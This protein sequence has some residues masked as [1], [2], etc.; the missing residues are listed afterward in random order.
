MPIDPLPLG[1]QTLVQRLADRLAQDIAAGLWTLLLPGYRTLA[2][3]YGTSRKTCSAALDLLQSRGVLDSATQGARRRIIQ[4]GT[5]PRPQDSKKKPEAGGVLLMITSSVSPIN[6]EGQALLRLYADCWRQQGGE[7]E[8]ITV[9]YA[10]YRTPALYLR[11]VIETHQSSALLLYIAPLKWVE[12]AMALLPTYLAGG[13]GREY[14]NASGDGYSLR[15]EVAAAAAELRRLG[16][17]R[18]VLPVEPFWSRLREF[19]YSGLRDAAPTGRLEPLDDVCPVFHESVPE[20]WQGYWDRLLAQQKP[21][22]VILVKEVHLLSLYGCC[23]GHRTQIPRD[24][25][26]VFL[27]YS[28]EL[29][30]CH[31]PPCQR[32]FPNEKAARSF[33]DWIKG[34]LEPHGF[35]LFGLQPVAGETMS[36]P[37]QAGVSF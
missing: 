20:V 21:T 6:V 19:A 13:E 27:G 4:T 34:G 9:D 14:P 25:S 35:R 11:K 24:L 3:R 17:R 23:M 5:A 16:H 12:A 1:Q 28:P 22:A 7:V 36:I 18:I 2:L 32:R 29:Q 30:W 26:I 33:R 37:A 15:Q 31:P 10:R 8:T